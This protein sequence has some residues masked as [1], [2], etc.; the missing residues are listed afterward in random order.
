[1]LK[2]T[3]KR[4]ISG[5]ITIFF[6][7]TV[8]FFAMQ[9]VPG[10]PISGNKALTPEIRHNLEVKYGLDK[11]IYEQYTIY[12]TNMLKGDFGISF[13]QQNRSVNDIIRD[14]FPV[15]AILGLLSILIATIAAVF[16]GTVAALYRNGLPDRLMMF[17]VIL[18]IS[19]PSFVFAA[20]A[21]YLVTEV[22]KKYGTEV[23]PVGGW[24]S[25]HH[26]ILPAVIL[27]LGSQAFMT[28]LMRSSMLEVINQDYIRTAKSKGVSTMR[29]FFS[30]QLRNAVLPVVTVLGPTIAFIT[31]GGFVVESVFSVPG[32][33]RYFIQAVQQLDYT[34][35][36]GL[37]SFY[38]AYLVLMVIVVDVVYGFI[39]PRI[40]VEKKRA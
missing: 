5:L 4:L 26:A 15:S 19:V 35:I 23:F 29:M 32:L 7:A 3:A 30:H 11:P 31:T 37:T 27:G 39:D 10:D 34:V 20:F 21:Q 22:N 9:A 16:C 12:M 17:F 28:R 8:T 6:I 38:G 24:G 33:G 13:T 36:M 1:M 18:G 40:S 2:Y 14:H 25:L